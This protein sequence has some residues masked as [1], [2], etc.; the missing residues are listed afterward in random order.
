MLVVGISAALMQSQ[1]ELGAV[2]LA[3]VADARSSVREKSNI[4]PQSSDNAITEFGFHVAFSGL[5]E[6]A[7]DE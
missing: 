7:F 1:L 4:I 6:H 5:I 2:A 3:K